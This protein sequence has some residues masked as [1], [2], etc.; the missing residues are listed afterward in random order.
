MATGRG[1]LSALLL[2]LGAATF[3]PRADQADMCRVVIHELAAE[4]LKFDLRAHGED[5]IYETVP[6][7]CF[8]LVRAYKLAPAEGVPEGAL[9]LVQR[10]ADGDEV[11]TAPGAPAPIAAGPSAVESYVRVKRE[12]EHF[13][14]RWHQELS[15]LIYRHVAKWSA[16][17]MAD[18]F[19]ARVVRGVKPERRAPA[20]RQRA[21][22]SARSALHDAPAERESGSAPGSRAAEREEAARYEEAFK[23]LDRDGSMRRLMQIE[24]HSPELML[25]DADAAQ[26]AVAVEHVAC[27]VCG[28]VVDEAHAR[29]AELAG[30]LAS[31][32]E[33]AL[34]DATEGL[35]EGDEPLNPMRPGNPP[36]WAERHEAR[37]PDALGG[38]WRVRALSPTERRARAKDAALYEQRVFSNAVLMRACRRALHDAPDDE[39]TLASA[40]LAARRLGERAPAAVRGAF[41]RAACA[42]EVA[43]VAK[44]EV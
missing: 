19:C 27:D 40:L 13:T 8:A 18:E 20:R 3:T 25:D 29:V 36:R 12:C 10:E 24:A 35:C 14:D 1:A 39:Q 38:R 43:A 23:L 16:A 44:E 2:G 17:Q 32:S 41:C 42:G 22:A 7:I 33:E 5:D 26:M 30:G 37:P 11:A 21:A 28:L 34:L 31:A 15:E 6:A 9:L 4:V